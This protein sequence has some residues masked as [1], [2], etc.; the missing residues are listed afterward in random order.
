MF[1][2]DLSE[3]LQIYCPAA[4]FLLIESVPLHFNN[5]PPPVSVLKNRL[6][7]SF[8]FGMILSLFIEVVA[9]RQSIKNVWQ[10]F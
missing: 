6:K 7:N 5:P 3:I 9:W 1:Q 10:H 4:G 8:F 2:I